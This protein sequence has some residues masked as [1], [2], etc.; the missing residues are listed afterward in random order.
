MEPRS[1][2]VLVTPHARGMTTVCVDGAVRKP[3][4]DISQLSQQHPPYDQNGI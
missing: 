1:R 2:G 4:D 3:R